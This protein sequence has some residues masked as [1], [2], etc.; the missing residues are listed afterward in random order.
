[1]KTVT[2]MKLL[3]IVSTVFGLTG[4][5][6]QLAADEGEAVRQVNC[7]EEGAG[8]QR[9]V[10]TGV[11]GNRS[12][13]VIRGVCF[14]TVRIARDDIT[15]RAHA[16]GGTINGS[17]IVV[18]GQRVTIDGLRIT[19]EGEGVSATDNASVNINNALLEQN[20]GS[21][22][23]AGRGA[24]V[25]LRGNMIR[26]NGEYGVLAQD[27]ANAQIRAGNTIESDVADFNVG[28]AVAGYRHATV[29]VRDGG[30]IIRNTATAAPGDPQDSGS[31]PGYA[32]D[33]EHVSVFRQDNGHALIHGHIYSFN[34]TS[35]DLRD[36]DIFGHIFIDGLNANFRLRN[37]T[38]TGGMNMFGPA[39]IRGD[40][41]FNGD[42]YCNGNFLFIGF[43]HNG[44]AIDCQ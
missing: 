34:L 25:V 24:L 12:T 39:S 15:L 6:P 40:V 42:I 3:L 9:A 2:L 8:I 5:S 41:T 32:I 28:S 33:M 10:D 37:S 43:E 22:V 27:G 1:M 16:E 11:S 30:N 17:I 31:A 26:L 38:V 23:F 29:G 20:A 44:D 36:A 35:V 21:G 4:L 14:E 19:G 13:I 18:G 7:G